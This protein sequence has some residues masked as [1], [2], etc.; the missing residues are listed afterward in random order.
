MDHE[1]AGKMRGMIRRV[2]LKNVADDG[3]TQTASVEVADGIWRDKVEVLQPYGVAT[4]VPEDGAVAL[5]LA[6]GG[7]EGDL[8]MLPVANPSTRMGGLKPGEVGLY[9]RHLDRLVVKDDGTI[10]ADAGTAVAFNVNGARLVLTESALTVKI[11]GLT[12]TFSDGGLDIVGGT[13][14]HNG[15]NIGSTHVHKGVES[16]PSTTGT[17]A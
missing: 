17:P 2:V 6:V 7:D 16:G 9:N 1:T 5:V 3:E 12:A 8:V 4:S 11:G 10:D 13:I 14:T 15:K